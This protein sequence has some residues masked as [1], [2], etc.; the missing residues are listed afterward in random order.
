MHWHADLLWHAARQRGTAA[1]YPREYAHLSKLENVQSAC[2]VTLARSLAKP[3]AE[4]RQFDGP[5]YRAGRAP[6]VSLLPF[7][8]IDA[9]HPQPLNSAA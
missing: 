2:F 4:A 8:S 5:A 1:E 9:Q 3:A 6:T 7:Y